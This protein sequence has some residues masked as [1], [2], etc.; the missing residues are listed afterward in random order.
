MNI[1]EL[2]HLNFLTPSPE[3]SSTH[4]SITRTQF[5]SPL[6]H[7]KLLPLTTPSPEL[8]STHHSITRTQFYSPTPNPLEE[9]S[10]ILISDAILL[11][12][13]IEQF[14]LPI[15]QTQLFL[16]PPFSF[17]PQTRLPLPPT[18][19]LFLPPSLAWY[20]SCWG[21]CFTAVVIGAGGGAIL[22][23]W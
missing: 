10:S 22:W 15:N 12:L 6:Y 7:P 9:P 8:S 16:L 17:P 5:Y 14:L 4:H 3:L 23:G 1:L 13:A 20:W 21:C 11:F 2:H 19:S 18:L